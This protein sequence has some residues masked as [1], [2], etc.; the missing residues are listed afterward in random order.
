[1]NASISSFENAQNNTENSLSN[2]TSTEN[3]AA[4]KTQAKEKRR[5]SFFSALMRVL[6]SVSF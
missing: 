6:S 3:H 2:K 4:E 1:M 5:E